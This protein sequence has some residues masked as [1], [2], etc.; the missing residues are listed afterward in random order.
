MC[1]VLI[2]DSP[3]DTTTFKLRLPQTKL[4]K[5]FILSMIFVRSILMRKTS[6]AFLSNNDD[7]LYFFKKHCNWVPKALILV[8]K[9][10]AIA[11]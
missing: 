6:I 7:F 4:Y 1:C 11:R 2:I 9:N 10:I 3:K 8:G 5:C